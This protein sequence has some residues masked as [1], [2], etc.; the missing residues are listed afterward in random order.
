MMMTAGRAAALRSALTHTLGQPLRFIPLVLATATVMASLLLGGI[1][2]WRLQPLEAPPW[3]RP[4]ALVL[5]AGAEGAVDLAALGLA[6]RKISGV[7]TADFIGR[8]A[9]LADLAQRPGLASLGLHE[10]RPN[11][12]PDA[13]VIH[14]AADLDPQAVEAAVG[15][16]RKV[17]DVDSVH[18][19]ADA[20]RRTWALARLARRLLV[21]A[22]AA[23]VAAVVVGLGVAATLRVLPDPEEIRL[24]DMLGAEPAAMRRPYVYTGALSL[25]IAAALAVWITIAVASGLDPL[26]A[27]LAQQYGVHWSS[28][29]LPAWYGLAFC[30]ATTVLG[31]AMAS[32]AVRLRIRAAIA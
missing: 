25:L 13:F 6:L 30:G 7:A 20:Y 16:M 10:L 4:Q 5:A 27:D 18:Y 26:V 31:A 19:Q 21:L 32:V 1:A 14:F 29:A 23:L 3:V 15:E 2:A 28:E 8:D 12:L 22:G 9:A 24:L 17:R 11:P